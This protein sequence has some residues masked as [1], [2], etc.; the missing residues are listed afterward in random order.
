MASLSGQ[1]LVEPC[2]DGFKLAAAVKHADQLYA[3][4]N[5]PVDQGIPLEV[6]PPQLR[7]QALAAL[8][9]IEGRLGQLAAFLLKGVDEALRV[10]WTVPGNVEADLDEVGLR[11]GELPDAPHQ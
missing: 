8:P 4:W 9:D 10:G 7:V 11:R 3:V 5:G 1:P 2:E 6:V